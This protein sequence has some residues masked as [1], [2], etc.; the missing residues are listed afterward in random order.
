MRI[1]FFSPLP[2]AK[3]GIADYS[4]AVLDHLA[5]L[6]EVETFSARPA[7]FDPSRYD[8][9]VYQLGN[10][11]YHSFVYEAALEHPGVVVM[12]EA[13]LHHLIA[14]VTISRGDWD[15]YL[16]EV[17]RNGGAEALEYA[18]R[19]VRTIQRGP[20]Y[21]LPMLRSVLDRSRA[22]IV[23]SVAVESDLRAHGFTGP[24]GR[25]PH[26]AWIVDADRMKYRVRLGLT[27]RTP[28]IGIFGFLKPYKRIA[29]SLRAFKR[30]V[31]VAPEARM[32]LVG[33]PHSEFPLESMIQSLG[34]SAQ[35]R[36]I[37][38]T[39]IEDFNGYLAASDIVL[40]LR[41]PTVGE[42]SGTLLRALGMGKAVVV[43]DVGS[44]REY[45]DEICIKAPVDA[46]EEDHL[47]EYLNLLVSRPELA[48][49]LGA[50][51]RAWVERECNWESVAQR[52]LNFLEA[53]VENREWQPPQPA[54]EKQER[55]APVEVSGDYIASWT[56]VEDGSRGYVE[57]HRTRLEKTLAITPPG[58][59]QDRILEMGAYL[60]ITPALK[61]RLGYGEVR[62]C[63][64]G[65]AGHVD[66]KHV[67]SENGE[68]FTCEVDLFN[69]EKDPFPYPDGYFSTVLCCELLEHL[70]T[71]PMH[72]M[73]ELNR[74][75]KPGGHLVLTTPNI[76]SLRAVAAILQGFHP[77]LFP[78]YI[79]PKKDGE[80]D[81]RHSR[82][83]TARE[84]QALLEVGGFEVTLLD[85][86]P[87]REEPKPELAWVEHLMER[88]ILSADHRGDGI[89]AVGRKVGAV[90]AR[91]PEW[92]YN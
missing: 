18:T 42:S 13:N 65:E 2:P 86:G 12:H 9:V 78:A 14:D 26:G 4:A 36:V 21:D 71:D 80:V 44:F 6:A 5:A 1:A 66:H 45:P 30:L 33:E 89:Y 51:A 34:L 8:L 68:E 43:S 10:N 92:L 85:T 35:A 41:F 91:Y 15:A 49:A 39:P 52:Y 7:K 55:P 46:S 3:S 57:T 81:A 63:Y 79:R 50:R 56:P 87:F 37:G 22:A 48:R 28:L 38:F 16:R 82:E 61:T 31:R 20:D 53:V 64:F 73:M 58:T 59:P 11:P 54:P 75:L 88:Y 32:I 70:T 17:E 23:H 69:A 67:V 76:A 90:K 19:Y 84:I 27:E 83:Y 24:I 77:M 74:I 47:F 60:Q 72:M 29:E 25:I 40:N 62:G